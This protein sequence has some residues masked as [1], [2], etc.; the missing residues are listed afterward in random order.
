MK[1]LRNEFPCLVSILLL[2][3]LLPSAGP[4][5]ARSDIP[6]SPGV[7]ACYTQRVS[8]DS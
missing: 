4:A 6:Q 7:L 2:S 5:T 3:G 8:V 1:A